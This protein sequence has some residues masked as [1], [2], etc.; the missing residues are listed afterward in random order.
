MSIDITYANNGNQDATG[1]V[2]SAELPTHSQF[3][4]LN[5]A[6]EW[7][8][9]GDSDQYQISIGALDV[10]EGDTVEFAVII[11]SDSLPSLT[12]IEFL[13]AIEDDGVNGEDPTPEDN[14]VTASIPIVKRRISRSTS[15][16]M[17]QSS[18][19]HHWFT[20]SVTPTLGSARPQ[21]L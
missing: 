20:R 4:S 17:Q 9:D 21:V 19:A 7:V 10:G 1:V 5:S 3:D 15:P 6:A 13:A 16:G 12:S 8:Y 2:L 11:D 14:E 18:P